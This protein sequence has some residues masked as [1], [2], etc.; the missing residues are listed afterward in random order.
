METVAPNWPVAKGDC[1]SG[2]LD[3]HIAVVTLASILEPYGGAAIWGSCKTENLGAEKIVLNIISNS[4]IRY[5]L[6]C[7]SESKGHLAGHTFVALHSNGI[8]HQGR[9]IGSEGAIPFIENL[10]QNMIA[11]F[12]AQVEII[13][14]IGLTDTVMIRRIVDAYMSKGDV[15]DEVPMV[16]KRSGKRRSFDHVASGDIIVSD[17]LMIDTT[18]GIVCDVDSE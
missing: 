5:V 11:R 4:N 14:R 3:S 15:F 12:Q 9:I 2:Q 18:L 16:I 8:D 17:G 10:D 13:E 6:V 7:G 1:Y